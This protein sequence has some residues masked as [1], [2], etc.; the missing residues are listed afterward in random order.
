MVTPQGPR[1]VE[2]NVRFGDPE[3][4]VLMVRLESD[5]VPYLPAAA[6]GT[7]AS[8]SPP[9][10]SE[11]VVLCVVLAVRGYPGEP[12]TGSAIIG[13]EADFG[14]NVMVFHASTARREDGALIAAGGRALNVCARGETLRLARDRAYGAIEKI[15][16][17]ESFFRR[18][19]GWRGFSG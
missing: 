5:I 14:P 3:C 9:I 13:A 10:W 17:P 2:F 6:T 15:C 1:L 19:I 7:L 12:E 11:S 16:W 4:Q 18:D 8:P